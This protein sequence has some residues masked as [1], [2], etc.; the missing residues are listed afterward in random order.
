VFT[1][2]NIVLTVPLLI[3][4]V[5]CC[6]C[7]KG[8]SDGSTKNAF[9]FKTSDGLSHVKINYISEKTVSYAISGKVLSG[10]RPDCVVMGIANNDSVGDS[11]VDSDENNE[12]YPVDEFINDN[13]KCYISIRIS[14]IDKKRL[15]INYV[16]CIQNL[17]PKCPVKTISFGRK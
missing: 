16:N 8:K 12:I 10:L 2:K 17:R 6:A 9:A 13:N 1:N 3:I 5:S 15:N 4:L 11:E 14:A 7:A